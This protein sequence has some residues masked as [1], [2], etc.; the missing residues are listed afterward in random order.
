MEVG[1][2]ASNS[3]NFFSLFKW[4]MYFKCSLSML[5]FYL[6]SM[7]TWASIVLSI[8]SALFGIGAFLIISFIFYTIFCLFKHRPNLLL[9][10]LILT[11][12]S[13][14]NPYNVYSEIL[15][16]YSYGQNSEK[17]F[18]SLSS[19]SIIDFICKEVSDMWVFIYGREP[20]SWI[21]GKLISLSNFLASRKNTFEL[22]SSDL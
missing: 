19:L 3:I 7:S 2:G 10:Y 14:S 12:Y 18:L 17:N 11:F 1:R 16:T 20:S 9:F 8:S 21:S 5:F 4:L 13:L 22:V 15:L 6:M